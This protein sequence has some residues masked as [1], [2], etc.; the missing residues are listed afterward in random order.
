MEITDIFLQVFTH[1]NKCSCHVYI[2]RMIFKYEMVHGSRAAAFLPWLGCSEV[3][4]MFAAGSY[5][6]MTGCALSCCCLYYWTVCSLSICWGIVTS[7]SNECCLPAGWTNLPL[8]C[9]C[10]VP[11][12]FHV[13]SHNPHD[14]A[15]L[16]PDSGA[17]LF[18]F[19]HLMFL[20][21]PPNHS[22]WPVPCRGSLP[23][24]FAVWDFFLSSWWG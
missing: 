6:E 12:F 13:H 17:L 24:V 2:S 5:W 21:L 20:F 8:F 18:F 15:F 10:A 19:S 7:A 11:D 22:G 23:I 16:S 14:S 3:R 1:I 4:T 9:L